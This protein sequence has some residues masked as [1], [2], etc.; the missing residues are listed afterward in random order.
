MC[1]ADDDDDG[2]GSSGKQMAGF[3]FPVCLFALFHGVSGLL[4][5]TN[6]VYILLVVLFVCLTLVEQL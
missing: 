6:V 4:E 1:K 5:Y 2:D 3:S